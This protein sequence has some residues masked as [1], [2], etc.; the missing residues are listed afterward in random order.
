MNRLSWKMMVVLAMG[1]LMF[2][3]LA[4]YAQAEGAHQ[5]IIEKEENQAA[6]VT[7][8]P[9]GE[10]EQPEDKQKSKIKDIVAQEQD[11]PE[12]KETISGE[13]ISSTDVHV[14]QSE[15]AGGKDTGV[16]GALGALLNFVGDWGVATGVEYWPS[17]VSTSFES[18]G[19]VWWDEKPA[20]YL[21]G[22]GI[23][24]NIPALDQL[25][26]EPNLMVFWGGGERSERRSAGY[27]RERL[28]ITSIKVGVD[29]LV[30]FSRPWYVMLGIRGVNV[31]STIDFETDIAAFRYQ[32]VLLDQEMVTELSLGGGVT[33]PRDW[34][35]CLR[36]G[37]EVYY[38]FA[39]YGDTGGVRLMATFVFPH[40]PEI[41]IVQE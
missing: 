8:T 40:E 28:T 30:P 18:G 34:A 10:E 6:T 29:F 19:T 13:D 36:A 11:H 3:V 9:L 14:S 22:L 38:Q 26:I 37:A 5:V 32:G 1:C 33:S 39:D 23:V 15:D 12:T 24:A 21:P 31:K 16:L 20:F 17:P 25:E 27:V 35:V 41:E 7:L 2:T 4:G